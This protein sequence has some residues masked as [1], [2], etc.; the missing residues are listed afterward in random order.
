MS[1]GE[2]TSGEITG[3]KRFVLL[4]RDGTINVERHYLSDP[5]EVELLPNAASGLAEMARLGLGLA[6]VTNQSGLGRGYFDAERLEEIHERLRELLREAA[7]VELDGIFCCPHLPDDGCRCRKPRA[8]LIEQA[9]RSLGFQPSQAFVIGDKPCD[10]ELGRGVDATTILVR[11]GYG[12][13]HEADAIV[14]PDYVV[15]DLREAARVIERLL[16]RR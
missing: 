6:V 2:V 14:Q 15:D 5:D 1:R 11:T 3:G 8:G 13:K 4:D 7:A 9:A 16:A 10:V 12:A